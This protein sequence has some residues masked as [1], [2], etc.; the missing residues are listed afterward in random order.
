MTRTAA[1][2]KL[3]TPKLQQQTLSVRISESQEHAPAWWFRA[4]DTGVTFQVLGRRVAIRERADASCVGH[5]R[6]PHGVGRVGA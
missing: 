1:T 3:R 6:H 2:A 5:A 4:H